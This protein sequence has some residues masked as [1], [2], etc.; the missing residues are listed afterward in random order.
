MRLGSVAII[1]L[2]Y[3]NATKHLKKFIFIKIYY[4]IKILPKKSG[5]GMTPPFLWAPL[6]FNKQ[7][8][9]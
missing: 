3:L 7:F 5:G 9:I 4:N 8:G 1:D 6:N 2:F